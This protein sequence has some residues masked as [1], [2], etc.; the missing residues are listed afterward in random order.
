MSYDF[1]YKIIVLGSVYNGKTSI[2]DRVV[3]DKFH[4][5]YQKKIGIDFSS[6]TREVSEID[7]TI[8]YRQ[9]LTNQPSG[10]LIKK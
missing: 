4:T 8:N 3:R 6:T 10:Y 9:L 5:K 1:L 7:K 2:I